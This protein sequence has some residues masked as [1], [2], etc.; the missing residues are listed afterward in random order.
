M[1]EE[2]LKAGD[3]VVLCARTGDQLGETVAQLAGQY[4]R[5][6]VQVGG[7]LRRAAG[8][9]LDMRVVRPKAATLHRTG[10]THRVAGHA[11]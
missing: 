4:G 3:R 11:V 10:R 8:L 9:H 6:R 7:P 1:A 5:D 2:F